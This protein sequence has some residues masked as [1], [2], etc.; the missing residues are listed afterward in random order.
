MKKSK[1][2][3]IQDSPVNCLQQKLWNS[4]I[5]MSAVLLKGN[6]KVVKE[7]KTTEKPWIKHYFPFG[8]CKRKQEQR[9]KYN[10]VV[11]HEL[12]FVL[13]YTQHI[14]LFMIVTVPWGIQQYYFLS[15]YDEVNIPQKSAQ[16]SYIY[17][18]IYCNHGSR[19]AH[20]AISLNGIDSLQHKAAVDIY[21]SHCQQQY[22]MKRPKPT[23]L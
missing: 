2:N 7:E 18:I 22:L 20:Q 5:S 1:I 19:C 10:V 17:C 16:I 15:E 6:C 13:W 21:F 9:P 12:I 4:Q 23:M 11:I 8:M 14:A 3:S